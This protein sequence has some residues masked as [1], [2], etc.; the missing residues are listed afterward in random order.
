LL[1][2][3]SER[4]NGG[5]S[6]YYGALPSRPALAPLRGVF[7]NL[8]TA[9]SPDGEAF[10][11]AAQRDYVQW[12]LSHGV[13]GVSVSLS[14]GEFGFQRSEERAA[15]IECVT[16]AV[17]GRVPVVAGVSELSLKDTCELAGRAEGCGASA[18]MV[19]P[20]SYF[21]LTEAEVLNYFAV[22]LRA[23]KIPLGIY[24]NPGATGID[25][26]APLYE[27]IIGLD[28]ARIVVSKE[29]SG[30]LART[31]DVLARCPGFSLLQGHARLMLGALLHGAP[32]TDFAL[33]SLLPR[34][35]LAIYDAAVQGK[36]QQAR[37]AYDRLLPVFR[38]MQKYDVTRLAKA[39]GPAFGL[40][41][42]P[43][44]PPVLELPQADRAEILR[45]A[46]EIREP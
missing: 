11:P 13:H 41:L 7:A 8:L 25:I 40:R 39:M 23:V 34:E 20:R 1:V 31:P 4:N 12:V 38:L 37:A 9:F 30:V 16:R 14:S 15:V 33:A 35:F 22:L 36:P 27:K 42:G 29:G 24:N 28:P 2:S 3:Q 6:L 21:V 45:V 26:G 43:H 5:E 18:L 46:R 17:S 32:G 10:E 19:M 44:R